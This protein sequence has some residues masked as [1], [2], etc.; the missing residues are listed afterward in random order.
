MNIIYDNMY[1]DGQ[2]L[3][4]QQT[5][6]KP[7]ISLKG[8]DTNKK[9]ILIM[10][11]PNAVNG[12]LIHWIVTNIHGNNFNAGKEL[13]T[14]KGPSPPKGSYIHNYIFALYEND[15][16]TSLQETSLRGTSL[17]G[18]SL[19]GRINENNRII[20]L[21]DL[22]HMLFVKGNPIY[23]KRFKSEYNTS[24]YIGGYK[25]KRQISKRRNNRKKKKTKR[26]KY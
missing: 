14:Y 5:R 2:F 17:R 25:R 16:F 8:L 13:L 9:Y 7:V 21:N 11:D 10:Y 4:P 1:V 18:T 23:E 6:F 24:E 12:N 26:K 20:E 15:N 3:K 22:L 19:R